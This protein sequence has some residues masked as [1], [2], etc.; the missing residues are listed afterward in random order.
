MRQG[1]RPDGNPRLLGSETCWRDLNNF[2]EKEIDRWG[3][4]DHVEAT[5]NGTTYNWIGA[6]Q[7]RVLGFGFRGQ[8]AEAILTDVFTAVVLDPGAL[9]LY[10]PDHPSRTFLEQRFVTLAHSKLCNIY[11]DRKRA[12]LRC[13]SFRSLLEGAPDET[14]PTP[15]PAP[16]SECTEETDSDDRE[17][18]ADRFRRFLSIQRNGANLVAWFNHRYNG[19]TDAGLL[20]AG[21]TVERLQQ[22]DLDVPHLAGIFCQK[23][24][25][26]EVVCQHFLAERAAFLA[27]APVLPTDPVAAP[28]TSTDLVAAPIPPSTTTSPAPP[29]VA[30]SPAPAGP[31]PASPA[32]PRALLDAQVVI[33]LGHARR[34]GTRVLSADG[35][36]K[37]V[38]TR[39]LTFLPPDG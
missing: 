12:T 33:V 11:R 22:A 39:T 20:A 25:R 28:V 31:I 36:W 7:E 1:M 10:K 23:W 3:F 9:W 15:P 37:W 34:E 26:L 29:A 24:P 14:K 17:L 38:P 21:W 6:L 19:G 2:V 32:A 30:S 13:L 5:A 16:P 8:D 35:S 4:R 18:W 27:S